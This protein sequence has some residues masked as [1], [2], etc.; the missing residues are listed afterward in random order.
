MKGHIL[1][2]VS[3][4]NVIYDIFHHKLLLLFMSYGRLSSKLYNI[5]L[6]ALISTIL[7]IMDT[8][9]TCY[10]HNTYGI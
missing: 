5:C 8:D 3:H 10:T 9:I 4:T 7:G 1:R 2:Y 6:L